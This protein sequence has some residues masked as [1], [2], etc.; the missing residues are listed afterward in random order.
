VQHRALQYATDTHRLLDV[1]LLLHLRHVL[2]EE[3]L[4]LGADLV[5]RG[6]AAFHHLDRGRIV[7]QRQQQVLEGDVFVT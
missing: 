7:E 6:T 2:V 4:E 3:L 5:D 1:A